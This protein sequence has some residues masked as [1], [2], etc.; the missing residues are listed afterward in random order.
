MHGRCS[1][2][3]YRKIRTS[4]WAERRDKGGIRMKKYK[5]GLVIAAFVCIFATAGCS[6]ALET[7]SEKFD[8]LVGNLLPAG[9]DSYGED[10]AVTVRVLTPTPTPEPTLSPTPT[11]PATRSARLNR[12]SRPVRRQP[13]S[14][15]IFRHRAT[16]RGKSTN[17]R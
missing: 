16:T 2:E 14:T 8:S 10:G 5:I 7:A 17:T 15:P 6:R 12:P 1:Q 3:N 11:L 4:A 9:S 13:Y